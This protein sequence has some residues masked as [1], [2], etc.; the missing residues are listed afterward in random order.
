MR[1]APSK[2]SCRSLLAAWRS[3]PREPTLW[4]LTLMAGTTPASDVRVDA[5]G[6]RAAR[7]ARNVPKDAT[8]PSFLVNAFRAA[9]SATMSLCQDRGDASHARRRVPA[10]TWTDNKGR[11]CAPRV[12]GPTTSYR[13]T[14]VWRRVCRS[15]IRTPQKLRTARTQCVGRATGAASNVRVLL[16]RTA[17]S[18]CPKCFFRMADAWKNARKVFTPPK[19]VACSATIRIANR[20][21]TAENV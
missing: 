2:V 8:S 6:V 13:S 12:S 14:S 10:V 16:T 19:N 9:K 5:V 1:P 4:I 20:V 11:P 18:V 3:V 21:M 15:F 7:N 17:S